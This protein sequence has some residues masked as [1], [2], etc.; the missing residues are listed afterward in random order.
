MVAR[1]SACYVA[2]EGGTDRIA[3]F[4]TLSAAGIPLAGLPEGL[5]HRL[6]EDSILSAARIGRLAVDI[7][8]QGRKLGSALLIDAAAKALAA[9]TEPHALIAT[10][11]T[12]EAKAFYG[13]HGFERLRFE[14]GCLAIPVSTLAILLGA[15]V[16]S[17][18]ATAA[19][20]A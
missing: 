8:F 14:P 10:A 4:Y 12:A 5:R 15:E 11:R 2:I 13:Q 17:Y 3:G 1:K 7:A 6:Q 9:G 18:M 19:R 16:P 20:A